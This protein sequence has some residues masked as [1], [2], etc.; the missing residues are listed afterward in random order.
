MNILTRSFAVLAAVMA[1]LTVA[2]TASAAS[3]AFDLRYTQSEG[4]LTR[5]VVTDLTPRADLR[6]SV[7]CPTGKPCPAG[8]TI[9]DARGT[10]ELKRLVD[11]QLPGGAKITVRATRGKLTAS[12]TLTIPKGA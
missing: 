12:S 11:A 2:E 8:F 3:L 9:R 4:R 1:L 10:I 5:L 6:V 7:K